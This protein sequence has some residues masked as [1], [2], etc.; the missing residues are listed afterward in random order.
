MES[1]YED[2]KAG[3][4]PGRMEELRRFQ[5][6]PRGKIGKRVVPGEAGEVPA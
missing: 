1:L 6:D 3:G 4:E 2:Q 5:N